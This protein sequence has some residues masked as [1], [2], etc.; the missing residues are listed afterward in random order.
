MLA[1]AGKPYARLMPLQPVA[2]PQ[3]KPGR[4]KG[5]KLKYPELIGVELHGSTALVVRGSR[6]RVI[7]KHPVKVLDRRPM[8]PGDHPEFLQVKPGESYDLCE[9]KLSPASSDEMADQ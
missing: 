1:K 4:L 3:R 5:L 6:M 2:K 9:R 7:G 8:D